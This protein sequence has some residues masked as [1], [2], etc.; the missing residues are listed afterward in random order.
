MRNTL[1]AI[2]VLAIVGIATYFLVFNKTPEMNTTTTN[3]AYTETNTTE[4]ST[5]TPDN[6]N[7]PVTV[8]ASA[9][10]I[11]VTPPPAPQAY[12]NIK[13]YIYSP[14]TLSIKAG[15]KVTWTNSDSVPH[16]VT[17]DTNGLL[18]SPIL[19]PGQSYSYTFTAVGT[20]NYHCAIHPTMMGGSVTVIQ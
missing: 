4:T 9:T 17:S 19:N 20:T 3:T 16:T 10:V 1:I 15:T 6:T 8:T 5:V 18:S 11:T 13:N 7:S 12:V 2:I 14:S